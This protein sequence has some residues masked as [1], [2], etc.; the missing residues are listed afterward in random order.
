MSSS[1]I[2]HDDVER[3]DPSTDTWNIISKMPS[4]RM[5][6]GATVS[7]DNI[8]LI[9]SYLK[10]FY[11]IYYIIY[12]F[13]TSNLLFFGFVLGGH[14]SQTILSN[15]D[16][17]DPNSNKWKQYWHSDIKRQNGRILTVAWNNIM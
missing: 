15:V 13:L 7:N 6:I 2:I 4:A 8:I 10:T 1:N 5:C 3:Y 11:Y 12:L 9:G 14:D 16:H 17:Y